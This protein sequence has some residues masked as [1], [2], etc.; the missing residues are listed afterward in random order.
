MA[1]PRGLPEKWADHWRR[2]WL[3]KARRNIAF[4][5]WLG[6]HGYLTPHFTKAEAASK[7]GRPIPRLLRPAAR[8]H[9]FRLERLRHE[10]GDKPLPILS[11]YRSPA[12]N[13][14][15]GG[16]RH[17]KHMAAIAVDLDDGWVDANGGQA[18]L[19]ELARDLGFKGV[20]VYPGGNM[21][22]D[23]RHGLFTTWSSWTR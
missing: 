13:A 15:V 21:H 14:A 17:S 18:R 5:H 6:R 2:P 16:A 19:T 10:L 12:H 1:L 4:R 3:P 7:D 9:A 8:N 22:F 23:S 20:G 11:W